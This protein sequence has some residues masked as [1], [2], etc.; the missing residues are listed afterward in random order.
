MNTYFIRTRL[1]CLIAMEIQREQ[2]QNNN[3]VAVFLYQKK[4][5]EDSPMTYA[6]Y[7]QF[8]EG[9]SKVFHIVT[10]DGL[11]KSFTKA[12]L[13]VGHTT[14]KGGTCFVASINSLPIALALRLCPL[15]RLE[16]F[17]DGA[18]NILPTSNYFKER[19]NRHIGLRGTLIYAVFPRG[20]TFW[21]R[22]FTRRHYTIFPSWENIV[23]RKKLR[24]LLFDWE[25]LLILEDIERLGESVAT[26]I[27]GTCFVDFPSCEYLKNVAQ[28][29]ASTSDLYIV[30]P[31]EPPV[32]EGENVK[33]FRSP[34]EALLVHLAKKRRIRV[35]HFN[36][37]T[38]YALE[39]ATNIEFVN[40]IDPMTFELAKEFQLMLAS[41]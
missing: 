19:S 21:M 26:V 4:R 23:D 38:A 10:G 37:S 24:I 30:H 36:S 22:Q 2:G 28:E 9:S 33:A 35:I 32:I 20:W 8:E 31:R 7:R 15:A 1:Q 34:A 39:G 6:L 14:L 12:L 13:V 41:D 18:A 27:L 3:Y 5:N 17:D 16:T 29:L 25:N 40:L 11:F